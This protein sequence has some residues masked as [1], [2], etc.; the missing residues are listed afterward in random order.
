[1]KIKKNHAIILALLFIF[2]GFIYINHKNFSKD[3]TIV[4]LKGVSVNEPIKDFSLASKSVFLWA[5]PVLYITDREGNIVKKIQREDENIEA[6]FANNYAFLYEKDLGK[7]QMYSEMGELLSTIDVKGDIFNISY[8][9]ANIIFHVVDDKN[10]ILYLMGNDST[11]TEIYRTGNQILTHD[12]VD[13]KNLSVAEIKNETTGYSSL[14]YNLNKG[15][16]T[17]QVLNH[18]VVMYL[19][20]DKRSVLALTDKA[21]YRF[22]N[23]GTKYEDRVPNISDI[24]VEGK[25]TYLLHSGIITEYNY[26][27][28]AGKKKIIAANVNK[29]ENI[30]G[31]IYVYGPSDVGGEIGNSGEFYTRLGYSLD[32]IKINGLLIGA[33]RNGNLSLYSVV[34]T[35]TIREDD[36]K[37]ETT[38]K[39][40]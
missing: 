6:F 39:E 7:V 15:E 36:N 13:D 21:I 9:N 27:L 32:K 20:R 2:L 8:E 28:K 25:K 22:M 14:V 1:M 34:N 16:K 4:R 24:L 3:R 12:V 33:L 26:I 38:Y 17:S 23:S 40:V 35:N 31:S 18:E 29:M 30:S 19:K 11:L 37:I 10:E 5:D